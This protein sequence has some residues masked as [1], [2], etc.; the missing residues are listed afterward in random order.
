MTPTGFVEVADRV[1][2]ARYAA[3][4]VSVGLVLGRTGALVVDTRA[5][6]AQGREMLAD[7]L[8]A[9]PGVRVTDVVTTHVHFDHTFGC[10]AFTGATLH[11]HE[12]VARDAVADAE[13]FKALLRAD[14]AASPEQ[15]YTAADVADVLSTP[16]WSPDRTVSGGG[17]IDLGSRLVELRHA[18]RGHTDGDLAVHVPDAGVV[19]LGDLVE[20]SA[21]P[22]YGDD[23]YPLDWGA[24]LTRHLDDMR[25]LGCDVVVPGH[26]RVVDPG[27]VRG[28]R[29]DALGV[30]ALVRGA[31]WAGTPVEQAERLSDPALPWA[32]GDLAAA[33]RRGYAH[34]GASSDRPSA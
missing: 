23:S 26:G 29:D 21:P 17:S 7:A 19:F 32:A 9:V 31:W 34:L 22:A 25:S 2:V 10:S 1:L 28:Q 12:H 24:T 30:A 33:V 3:W 15:G 20:A 27:F 8:R 13:R 14:P 5:G 11:A 18:G 16:P 4:D 6:P